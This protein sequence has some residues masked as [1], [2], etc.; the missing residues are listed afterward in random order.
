MT[1]MAIS[2]LLATNIL[3]IIY[4]FKL[5][6]NRQKDYMYFIFNTLFFAAFGK[7]M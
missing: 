5:F 4:L 2:P 6:S 3:L 7:G 1:L